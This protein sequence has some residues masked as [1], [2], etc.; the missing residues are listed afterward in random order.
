MNDQEI[1][2][3]I[4]EVCGWTINEIEILGMTDVAVLPTG[5]SV[6]D[7]GAVWKYSGIGLPDYL[8]DFN[9]CAEMENNLT[10]EQQE[11]YA[12]HLSQ[13][14]PQRLNC[15][16]AADGWPDIMV[17]REFDALHATARQRCEAFLRTLN[18]WIEH[19]PD[20]SS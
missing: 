5:V 19:S 13:L 3:A 6:N 20:A 10:E 18:L 8:N 11:I 16:P 1:N 7:D 12:Y 14:V 2:I 17:H 9:A 15:G 4:A